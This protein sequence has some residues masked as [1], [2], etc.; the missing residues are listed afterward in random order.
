MAK[1]DGLKFFLNIFLMWTISFLFKGCFY[2]LFKNEFI[3]FNWRLITLQYCGGFCHTSTRISHGHSCVPHP[4]PPHRLPHPIP[5]GC[6]RALVLAPCSMHWAC[7]GH[8]LTWSTESALLFIMIKSLKCVVYF[9]PQHIT[10]GMAVVQV[11]SVTC[12]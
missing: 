12:S 11:L 8:L 7:T 2:Y 10:A 4:E 5:L 3:Y 1:G 6:S 9:T